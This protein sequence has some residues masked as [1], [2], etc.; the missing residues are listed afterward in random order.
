MASC[1]GRLQLCTRSCAVRRGCWRP[2]VRGAL[3]AAPLL[4][5]AAA[6]VSAAADGEEPTLWLITQDG[7][8]LRSTSSQ[9]LVLRPGEIV[10]AILE[11]SDDEWA[12]LTASETARLLHGDSEYDCPADEAL[13]QVRSDGVALFGGRVRGSNELWFA[14]K[15]PLTTVLR[16]QPAPIVAHAPIADLKKMSTMDGRKGARR[17]PPRP[18]RRVHFFSLP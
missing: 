1:D 7:V 15:A 12:R 10:E 13:L 18:C 5:T 3:T 14:R 16:H 8:S 9:T 11:A 6:S 2:R 17:C 4:S